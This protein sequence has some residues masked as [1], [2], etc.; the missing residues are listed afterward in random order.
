MQVSLPTQSCVLVALVSLSLSLLVASVCFG[1]YGV[2]GL[3]AVVSTHV[4]TQ[5]VS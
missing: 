5:R 2:V 3:A 4:D 1:E